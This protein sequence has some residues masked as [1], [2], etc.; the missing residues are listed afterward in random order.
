MDRKERAVAFKHDRNNCCQA[1]LL[2]YQEELGLSEET[3]KKLGAGLGLGGGTMEGTCGALCAAAM[4]LG[5]KTS[6]GRPVTKQAGQLQAAFKEKSGAVTC[7]DLKGVDTGV[8]LC[9][10][11]DCVRNAVEVLEEMK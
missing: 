7:R 3:L 4:V 6:D 8:V 1:V 11:D 5:M 2:A 9:A 10:C